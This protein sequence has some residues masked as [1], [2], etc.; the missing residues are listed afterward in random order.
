MNNP[1][2]PFTAH[3]LRAA[4]RLLGEISARAGDHYD[5]VE[6][7]CAGWATGLIAADPATPQPAYT[8]PPQAPAELG[9]FVEASFTADQA[10]PA[11]PTEDELRLQ[12][13]CL[14]SLAAAVPTVLQWRVD[15]CRDRGWP[16][17][18]IGEAL[19]ISEQGAHSRFRRTR[20]P[21]RDEFN[22]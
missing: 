18:R 12:L 8:T 13:V 3:Q 20:T 16:W 10:P 2:Q 5:V 6:E 17:K 11:P 14:S 7:F 22:R 19:E 15:D 1:T 21:A 9:A 4:A